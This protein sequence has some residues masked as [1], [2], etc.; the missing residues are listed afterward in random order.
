MD[1]SGF[2]SKTFDWL[3]VSNPLRL[4]RQR[5]RRE[6]KPT[7]L[8]ATRPAVEI[9]STPYIYDRGKGNELVKY[10]TFAEV[11]VRSHRVVATDDDEFLEKK[12]T[13]TKIDQNQSFATARRWTSSRR[14]VIGVTAYAVNGYT[15]M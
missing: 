5:K 14:V 1:F 13:T 2:R 8:W 6:L 3:T 7:N 9:V 11:C 12:K 10:M 15:T 4:A